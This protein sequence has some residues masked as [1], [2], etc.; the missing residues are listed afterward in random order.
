MALGSS[1]PPEVPAKVAQAVPPATNTAGA[2]LAIEPPSAVPLDP[3][4][5][6]I[7]PTDTCAATNPNLRCC[8]NCSCYDLTTAN[9][10]GRGG[11]GGGAAEVCCNSTCRCVN[12]FLTDPNNCGA[13]GNVCA[14][15]LACCAGVCTNTSGDVDN[16]GSCGTVCGTS[17]CGGRFACQSGVCDSCCRN[18]QCPNDQV[19]FRTGSTSNFH[20]GT[21]TCNGNL[22]CRNANV[23]DDA[24]LDN[25]SSCNGSDCRT[26][27]TMGTF[28]CVDYYDDATHCIS[29]GNN[30]CTGPTTCQHNPGSGCTPTPGCQICCKNRVVKTFASTCP[31]A[32]CSNSVFSR[33]CP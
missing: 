12:S 19:C 31:D 7:S 10:C 18:S 25:H 28:H 16:C 4:A 24:D 17:P 2:R 13:C 33:G 11:N 29:Q 6:S 15:G 21:K 22:M 3:C 20:C 1:T 27:T 5:C 26:C 8:D 23:K 14:A 30:L 32:V 9:N